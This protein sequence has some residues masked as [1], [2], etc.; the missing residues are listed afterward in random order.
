MFIWLGLDA[1]D[2]FS[3][4][5]SRVFDF[6]L[7]LGIDGSRDSF[8]FHVSFKISFEVPDGRFEEIAD[9]VVGYYRTLH[10]FTLF[11]RA[12]EKEE[13]IVWVRYREEP[14]LSEI[15]QNLN[16][17]LL[18]KFGIAMHPYDYDDLFH[19]TLYMD[20]DAEILARAFDAVKDTPLP[21]SV[22]ADRF[23]LGVS[24]TGDIGSYV[25]CRTVTAE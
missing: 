9:A 22:T 11:P 12:I 23:A 24:P 13:G 14:Y 21:T 6:D 16:R 15:K 5:K 18:D 2:A 19:T 10:G 3:R 1:D 25:I 17:L 20:E 4:L 7:A 8:P